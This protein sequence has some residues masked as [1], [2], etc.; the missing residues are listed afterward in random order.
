M[1][2][3]LASGAAVPEAGAVSVNRPR[4][5]KKRA[6]IGR[7]ACNCQ[8]V[9]LMSQ[10]LQ[11]RIR[12][13]LGAQAMEHDVGRAAAQAQCARQSLRRSVTRRSYGQP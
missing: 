6:V 8:A 5:A 2:E 7:V 10:V 3:A 9:V 1:G 4:R 13:E 11:S 12:P